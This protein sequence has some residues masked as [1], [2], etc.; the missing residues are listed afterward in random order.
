MA[1]Y[2]ADGVGYS[3][4]LS[5]SRRN[6]NCVA[7]KKPRLF[8]SQSNLHF[9]PSHT[10]HQ[11][12]NMVLK[13]S[14]FVSG[15]GWFILSVAAFAA[16]P[17]P[18]DPL[19]IRLDNGWKGVYGQGDAYAE[20]LLKG[21]DVKLQDPHHIMLK[22]GLGMMVT[23]AAKR[24]LGG[25]DLLSRHAE[26][27]LAYWQQHAAKVESATRNDLRGERD[28]LRVTEI[29]LHNAPG[30][31]MRIYMLA[32]ASDEG[33]FVLSIS[34]ANAGIDSM[35]REIAASFKL[36]NHPLDSDEVKRLSLAASGR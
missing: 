34:P 17:V 20:Y 21:A 31:Q 11:P 6:S 22:Q 26:W 5:C 19:Y 3:R 23:F 8:D 10:Y 36:V 9:H 7:Q 12:M 35:V 25:G 14:W 30:A 13:K 18:S 33:V 28:D 32:L 24:D 4:F 16:G 2:P 1:A 27:E 29:T 15:V